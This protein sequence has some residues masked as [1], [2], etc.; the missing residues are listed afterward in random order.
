LVRRGLGASPLA[1]DAPRQQRLDRAH[2]KAFGAVVAKRNL[3]AE[4]EE[5]FRDARKGET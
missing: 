5:A 2:G 3:R 4:V 1:P